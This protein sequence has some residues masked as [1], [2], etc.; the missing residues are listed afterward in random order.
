MLRFQ[1]EFYSKIK[2]AWLNDCV[3]FF[4]TQQPGSSFIDIFEGV[5][6]Q[7]LLEDIKNVC[8]ITI[9]NEFR[10]RS[11]IWTLNKN[12]FLQMQFIVEISKKASI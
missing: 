10:T 6:E 7:I 3:N 11:D 1:T 8:D 12:L 9:P 5:I 4:L 2:L